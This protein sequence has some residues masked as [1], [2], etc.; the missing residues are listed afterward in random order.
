MSNSS[1]AKRILD[2]DKFSDQF[3]T[4][5]RALR[6]LMIY[7]GIW[8]EKKN[9]KLY[10]LLWY[11]HS[12]IF[13]FLLSGL[14]CGLVIIRHDMNKVLS[15][16]SVTSGLIYFIG[17]WFTFSW[18]K[19]L[20]KKLTYSMD[21]DWI[22]LANKTLIQ[23]SVPDSVQI[24][25]KHYGSL[26]IYVYII[27]FVLFIVDTNL[28][29][30]YLRATNHHDNLTD[31]DNM[32]PLTHS[33]YPGIDYDRDYIIRF[34]AAAQILC[35]TSS[36]VVSTAVDG[37]FVITVLHTTGQLEIL[38]LFIERMKYDSP[39]S[40]CHRTNVKEMVKRHQMLLSVAD[41]IQECFGAITFMRVSIS[42][43][44]IC[45]SAHTFLGELQKSEQSHVIALKY[46]FVCFTALANVFVYC[47]V[48]DTLTS[49]G[50]AIRSHIYNSEWYNA[51]SSVNL[52]LPIVTIK[53]SQPIIISAAKIF[54]LTL[55][56]FTVLIK[57]IASYISALRAMS[58]SH[59]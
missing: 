9:E 18:H 57:S 40:E 1:R 47:L 17:K 30:D 12:T 2:R 48:S 41:D 56:N 42:F 50:L 20:I 55:Q 11:F 59:I 45:S 28:I 49:Q 54:P 46:G 29:V 31:L 22:N 37:F 24:M 4:A 7:M 23:A 19:V 36:F 51:T 15:N 16:L 39:D 35:T 43:V 52:S 21:E 5:I 8:P 34:L 44:G 58:V 10:T 13:L 53:S 26:N 3:V 14:V 27:L 25:M 33:W 6:C 38:G 32:L